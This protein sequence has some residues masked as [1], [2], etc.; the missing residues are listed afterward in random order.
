MEKSSKS[1]LLHHSDNATSRKFLQDNAIYSDI[2]DK[3][4]K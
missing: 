2:S 3:R 4:V 1:L